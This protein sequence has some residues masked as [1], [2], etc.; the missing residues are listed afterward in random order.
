[1]ADSALQIDFEDAATIQAY[2][3]DFI[4]IIKGGNRT[5][6][7]KKAA[8]ALSKLT[9]WSTRNKLKFSVEKT[10]MI[11]FPKGTKIESNPPRIKWNNIPL[12]RQDTLQYLGFLLDKKLTWIPH[13]TEM[14]NKTNIIINSINRT[15]NERWTLR[16]RIMKDLYLRAVER[17]IL[18]GSPVWMSDTV[19][20][21]TKL[22]QI[23]RIALLKMTSAFTT[24][25]TAALQILAGVL[26]LDLKAHREKMIYRMLHYKEDAIHDGICILQFDAIEKVR[27]DAQLHPATPRRI[28]WSKFL[29][30][31]QGL[32]IFTDGSR[33]NNQVGAAFVAFY[34]GQEIHRE[35][36]RLSDDA[37]VYQAESQAL[38]KAALWAGKHPSEQISFFTDSMSVLQ[39]MNKR[40]KVAE[41]AATLKEIIKSLN[42]R[43]LLCWVR[44]HTGLHGN[45]LADA[46]AKTATSRTAID[47]EVP[48]STDA[49]KR[50]ITKYL[51]DV[52]QDR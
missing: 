34:H 39:A 45:E 5:I 40:G 49:A 42:R 50:L 3:D 35:G 22:A 21:Q 28:P 48:I 46:H 51:C 27:D 38:K 20:V 16:G 43:T 18:Y 29:P 15:M 24:T 12:R 2:A 47:V 10:Q 23:Q 14:R 33:I 32:E 1:M 36:Y 52:W 4:I 25:S 6:I 41:H 19:R 17:M 8:I 11:L 31:G 44:G 30:S 9:E 37:T 13:L 7:E 26:P